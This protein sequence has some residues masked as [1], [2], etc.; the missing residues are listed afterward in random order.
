MK[1]LI[2]LLL[3]PVVVAGSFM[4]CGEK[5]VHEPEL[6]RG[7]LVRVTTDGGQQPDWSDDGSLIL[8]RYSV[9]D[10]QSVYSIPPEGGEPSKLLELTADDLDFPRWHPDMSTGLIAFILRMDEEEFGIF[11]YDTQ[12]DELDTLLVSKK[13][14]TGLD[15]TRDGNYLA[16]TREPSSTSGIWLLPLAGGDPIQLVKPTPWYLVSDLS[17]DR[18]SDTISYLEFEKAKSAWNLFYI[19]QEGGDPTRITDFPT[20]EVLSDQER[21]PDGTQYFIRRHQTTVVPYRY[22]IFL[23]PTAGGKAE[24]I[25]TMLRNSPSN[26]TW[27][28]EGTAI[29]FHRWEPDLQ[30]SNIF[31]VDLSE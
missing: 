11:S 29:A 8:Y 21:S 14:F 24:Q 4:V 20:V 5:G 2:L 13:E 12:N 22:H 18:N 27:S 26:P 19:N 9:G 17:C 15:F 6:A 25:T 10:L 16:Y 7:T 3:L 23:L 28:P 30:V 31:Y 1:R